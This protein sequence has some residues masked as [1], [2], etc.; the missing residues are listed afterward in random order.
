MLPDIVMPQMSG[1][2]LAKRLSIDRPGMRVL[3]MSGYTDDSF[4]RRG[5]LDAK[6]CFCKSRSRWIRSLRKCAK[7]WTRRLLDDS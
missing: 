1:P 7:C 5:L 4:V 6:M 2:E 3:C